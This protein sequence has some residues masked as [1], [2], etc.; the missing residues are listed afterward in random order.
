[1]HIPY[2]EK[3]LKALSQSSADMRA[4]ES[5]NLSVRESPTSKLAIM[6]FLSTPLNA[7]NASSARS[8]DIRDFKSNE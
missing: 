4:V 8:D 7:E 5:S 6:S 3:I 1:M 2:Q